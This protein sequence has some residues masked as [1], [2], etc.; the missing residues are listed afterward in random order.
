MVYGVFG[1]KV[2]AKMALVL[3]REEG[4]LKRYAH[5]GTGNYH[6]GTSRIYTDFGLITADKQITMDVNTLFWEIT[7]LGNPFI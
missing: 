6:Q 3:R 5:L 2:H 1:Y 4:R 7:G